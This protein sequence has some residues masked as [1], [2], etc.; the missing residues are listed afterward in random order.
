LV[1]DALEKKIEPAAPPR[2]GASALCRQPPAAERAL[3]SCFVNARMMDTV[4]DLG[5]NDEI[6]EGLANRT[7]ERFANDW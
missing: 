3:W 7:N 4:L 2:G 5:P 1:S 6:V